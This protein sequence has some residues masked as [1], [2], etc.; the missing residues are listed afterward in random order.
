[1]GERSTKS[2][3]VMLLSGVLALILWCFVTWELPAERRF[4]VPVR[5]VNA[6]PGMIITGLPSRLQVVVSGPRLPLTLISSRMGGVDLDLVGIGEGVTVFP[7]VER[8][9]KIPPHLN[10][11]MISPARIELRLA[12]SQQ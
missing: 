6:A 8:L 10:I 3:A 11:V 1:M 12:K 9:L 5:V 2:Y 7:V 4:L